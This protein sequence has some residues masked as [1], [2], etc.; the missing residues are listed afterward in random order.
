MTLLSKLWLSVKI[1]ISDSK[2]NLKIRDYLICHVSYMILCYSYVGDMRSIIWPS[3][4]KNEP[5]TLTESTHSQGSQNHAIF[6]RL[7]NFVYSFV[8]LCN[9]RNECAG[10]SSRASTRTNRNWANTIWDSPFVLSTFTVEITIV[11]LWD[12]TCFGQISPQ[13]SYFRIFK[14]HRI[15]GSFTMAIQLGQFINIWAFSIK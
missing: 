6:I 15:N 13:K 10:L 2:W 8:E 1:I 3:E 9:I 7:S 5:K 4:G 14:Y 11:W 12:E